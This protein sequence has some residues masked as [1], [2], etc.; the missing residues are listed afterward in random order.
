MTLGDMYI[1]QRLSIPQISEISGMSRSTVRRRL[2]ESG[3]ELRSRAE[4]VL[5]SAPR[6]SS[7]LMGKAKPPFSAIHRQRISSSRKIWADLHAKG[8][9]VTSKGY[10]EYTRGEH[11]GR[12]V[13]TVIIEKEI[14]RRINK[15]ECVHHEDER[16]DNNDRRNL[17]LMTRSAHT[18]LHRRSQ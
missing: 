11:K 18:S 1:E 2:I 4:G 14:G 9:R 3:I 5:I 7:K 17:L 16:R 13:H 8:T 15:H 12:R 10:I 6:I